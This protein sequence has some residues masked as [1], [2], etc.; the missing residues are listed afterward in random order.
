M[1]AKIKSNEAIEFANWL[2]N[3]WFK[4]TSDGWKIDIKNPECGIEILGVNWFMTEDLYKHFVENGS[5]AYTDF[6]HSKLWKK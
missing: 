1:T 6:D 5:E 2:A 4:P 3:Q